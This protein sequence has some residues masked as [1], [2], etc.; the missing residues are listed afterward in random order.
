MECNLNKH[1]HTHFFFF[2]PDSGGKMVNS[3]L[4]GGLGHFCEPRTKEPPDLRE[5]RQYCCVEHLLLPGF[6]TLL[7][8]VAFLEFCRGIFASA[9]FLCFFSFSS[10]IIC[11]CL[12]LTETAIRGSEDDCI[13]HFCERKGDNV[14]CC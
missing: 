10:R 1:T 13:E 3:P 12:P 11:P 6:R 7:L 8:S 4:L 2:R 14:D 5:K 9:C